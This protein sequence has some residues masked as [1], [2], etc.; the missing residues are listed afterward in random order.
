MS[1]LVHEILA[2]RRKTRVARR[3]RLSTRQQLQEVLSVAVAF[4]LGGQDL[5]LCIVDPAEAPGNLLGT[6]DLEALPGLDRGDELG[7]L[8]QAF[9]RTGIEPGEAAPELRDIEPPSPQILIVEIG[10]LELAAGRGF[11]VPAISATC[12]S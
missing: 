9:R 12:S 4:E 7:R 11:N 8:P 6:G 10:D 3:L 5:E 1:W 2:S